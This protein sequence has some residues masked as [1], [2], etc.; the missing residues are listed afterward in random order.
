MPDIQK[1][2]SSSAMQ[3]SLR[4]YLEHSISSTHTALSLRLDALSAVIKQRDS[5]LQLQAKEYERRLDSLNH[6]HK[7]ATR[8][9]AITLSKTSFDDYIKSNTLQIDTRFNGTLSKIEAV[10]L[11][12]EVAAR[13]IDARLRNL[14]G[15][16]AEF[17]GAYTSR[18]STSAEWMKNVP[19]IISLLVAII[20][21]MFAFTKR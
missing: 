6:A 1:T 12:G 15:S 8:A 9:Q 19:T 17:H 7:E 20:A 10:Q 11:S 16:G 5:A 3:V 14:E 2:E 4:E 13:S 18:M 21:L